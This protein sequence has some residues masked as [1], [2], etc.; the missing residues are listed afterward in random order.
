MVQVVF[1]IFQRLAEA[2]EMD[3]LP[4]PQKADR[5]QHIRIVHQPDDVVVGRARLLLCRHILMQVGD[6]VALAGKAQRI[7]RRAAGGRKI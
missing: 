5:R 2:L 6:G 4:L 3:D 1:H 7:K